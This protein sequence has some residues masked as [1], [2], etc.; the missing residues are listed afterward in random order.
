MSKFPKAI[1]TLAL[2]MALLISVAI[3]KAIGLA[4]NEDAI[5]DLIALLPSGP[6]LLLQVEKEKLARG[7]FTST[8]SLS[9]NYTI[10]ALDPISVV[11]DFDIDH[12]PFLSTDNG[13]RFGFAHARVTPKFKLNNLQ[14]DSN[15]MPEQVGLNMSL[16]ADFKR[17]LSLEFSASPFNESNPTQAISFEGLGGSLIVRGDQTAEAVMTLNNIALQDTPNNQRIEIKNASLSAKTTAINSP[18]APSSIEFKLPLISSNSLSMKIENLAFS[19]TVSK[20]TTSNSVILRQTA[21]LGAAT[22]DMPLQSGRWHLELS[23]LNEESLTQFYAILSRLQL[24]RNNTS[25]SA[26]RESGQLIER[27]GLLLLNN[28]LSLNSAFNI[29]AYE[30]S[31]NGEL[32]LRFNGVPLLRNIMGLNIKEA[33]AATRFSVNFDL[34]LEALSRSPVS[35]MID[36]FLQDGYI[37]ISNGRVKINASLNNSII[38]LNG[39]S[40]PV[41]QYF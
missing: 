29:E 21:T 1:L 19:S 16:I 30:G 7:W 37:V 3:P 33:I 9:L 14:L 34:D 27:L 20:A 25:S 31:H 23:E 4:I 13:L 41:E 10:A 6:D 39:Q 26:I 15:D 24:L 28:P 32:T 38:D 22:G 5:D 2:L 11:L 18:A 12:G 17:T 35:E 36:P 8:G 40:T